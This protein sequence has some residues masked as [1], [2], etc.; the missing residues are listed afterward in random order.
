[1]PTVPDAGIAPISAPILAVQGVS[2]VFGGLIAVND[3][4]FEVRRGEIFGD[5]PNGARDDPVLARWAVSRSR[6]WEKSCSMDRRSSRSRPMRSATS[7]SP[8]HFRSSRGLSKPDGSGSGGGR[9]ARPEQSDPMRL[10]SRTAS[11]T[12]CRSHRSATWPAPISRL[13]NSAGS[14]SHGHWRQGQTHPARR[15]P[16]WGSRRGQADEA[17]KGVR[18]I[19]DDGV[20]VLIIEHMV[21]AVMTSLCRPYRRSGCGEKISLGTPGE[22]GNDPRV[23]EAY[24]G[25][26]A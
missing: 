19:R 15:N 25:N 20:T 7:A 3:V 1:M 26:V 11:S 2:K 17:I 12:G 8:A 13:P 6:A 4:S 24:L 16:G 5:R 14:R 18:A 22:V 21:R 9:C 23:I 10:S